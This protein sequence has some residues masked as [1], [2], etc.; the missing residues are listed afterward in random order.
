M[1]KTLTQRDHNL[2]ETLIN[3]MFIKAEDGT[4]DALKCAECWFKKSAAIDRDIR[5]RFGEHVEQAIRGDYNYWMQSPVGCVGLMILVDQFP[6]NIYRDTKGMFAG[7]TVA[8][9]IVN[10]SHDWQSALSPVHQLF[11]PELILTHH[12]NLESQKRCV[13]H[14]EE[15]KEY[16][17]PDFWGFQLI[18]VKH[19]EVIEQFGHFPHRNDI[20]R[21]KSTPE[22]VEFIL[23]PSHRFDLAA[24]IDPATGKMMFGRD[25]NALWTLFHSE[26]RAR[27]QFEHLLTGGKVALSAYQVSQE[28]EDQY[29]TLFGQL[30]IDG[31]GDLD[32]QELAVL[33]ESTGKAYS[34]E[35]LQKFVT[36][37][38]KNNR[39]DSNG[40][41][42]EQFVEIM[43]TD[44]E[45]A[46]IPPTISD[47][48]SMFD[49]DSDGQITTEELFL[50]VNAI[51]PKITS[52]EIESM[53]KYADL[54][55][56]K[57]ISLDEFQ[58]LVIE[59]HSK[60]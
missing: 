34:M 10:Q 22:E 49:L 29:R 9:E 13:Q 47:F 16:L 50:C 6:R 31:S 52:S 12:E 39:N 48:F 51:N 46:S 54:D 55:G 8:L 43:E 18:F 4:P 59:L 38:A 26:L 30:D 3:Y 28:T 1:R 14:Y 17:P 36:N 33:F 53:F 45:E 20:L 44:L 42:F 21:R 40:I 60:G 56:N 7:E 15:I 58:Q 25:P 35:K 23:N 19:L 32:A 57:L 11:T 27:T 41:R 5:K 24:R 2:I 37:L